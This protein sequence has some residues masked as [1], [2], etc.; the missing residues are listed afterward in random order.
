MGEDNQ[1]KDQNGV[2]SLL[3]GLNQE[4][5]EREIAEKAKN[6]SIGYV[7][8]T[9]LPINIDLLDII[10]RE[11]S[12]KAQVM[13]FF[14]VGKKLRLAV[15]DPEKEETK[16]LIKELKEKDFDIHLSLC[17][18]ESLVFAQQKYKS[19]LHFEEKELIAE[20]SA[21]VDNV[22][23]EID[24]IREL[25]EKLKDLK[26]DEALN[27]LHVEILRL[28]ASDL[29]FEPQKNSYRI[30]ARIDGLLTDF[31]DLDLNTSQGLVR[32]IKH[33]ARMKL[34]V[35]NVPQDGKYSF[36]ATE[37][38]VD[39]RVSTLPA[40]NGES[41]V[42][43]FL[44]PK[45][46]LLSLEQLGFSEKALVRFR[47][48]VSLT[49]GLI[50]ATG[51][52]GSGKTTTLHSVLHEINTPDKKIIT[53]EDPVEFQIPGVVQCEVKEDQEFTFA[54]G[55]KSVLRQ[56]P[57]IV[58][59]GEIRDQTTA[60][61]AVQASLT[62]HLVL[63][64]LHTNSSADAIPRL[65]NMGVAPFVLAPAVKCIV[66]QRLVRTLCKDCLQYEEPEEIV[67]REI[68]QVVDNLNN[69]GEKIEL[70]TKL[71]IAK[72]CDKCSNTGYKGITAVSEVLFIDATLENMIYKNPTDMEIIK[73][74]TENGMRTMWEEGILKIINGETSFD[75][76][77]RHINKQ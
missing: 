17:S 64:T 25:P 11:Q 69:R 9:K 12:I 54:S 18:E 30:R 55:L 36:K 10:S 76:I 41:I 7:D 39:V 45:K 32:Q 26:S 73:Y 16:N 13:P 62:G 19:E 57:N 35:V 50:L 28:N 68:K 66:A 70:P 5:K 38:S 43:R 47:Q 27:L 75:E 61:T 56:D 72:G 60:E 4:F 71:P 63:S 53:I 40:K 49:N 51:P 34:N 37:R 24:S 46:G 15:I 6:M 2:K 67:L 33:L 42:M 21:R 8:L 22:A 65:L 44:D 74:A 31:F 3:T 20:D 1:N 58:M 29:H 14:K 52:T 59:I 23:Q 77:V 48:A